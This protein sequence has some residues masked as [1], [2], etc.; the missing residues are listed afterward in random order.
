MRA[1][2]T[3]IV[4][5]CYYYGHHHHLVACSSRSSSMSRGGLVI[6][7]VSAAR[8]RQR[9]PTITNANK[10]AAGASLSLFVAPRDS[11]I[12]RP[13]STFHAQH[14]GRFYANI[15]QPSSAT[16]LARTGGTAAHGAR[17]G[18]F[19]HMS[20]VPWSVCVSAM[21]VSRA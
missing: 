8:S 7:L 18:L 20:D 3:I 14:V 10:G 9:R 19:L 6:Q 1:V 16:V 2:A 11:A 5:I 4:P 17:C 12:A 15:T 13:C 21:P